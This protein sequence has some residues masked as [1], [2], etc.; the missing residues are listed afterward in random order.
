L[1]ITGYA[2]A[3]KD[4]T[5]AGAGAAFTVGDL[6]LLEAAAL[7]S[8]A[9]KD[10][11]VLEERGWALFAS[12]EH[13]ASRLR[14]S[15]QYLENHGYRDLSGQFG[16]VTLDQKATA[17]V[18]LNMGRAGQFDFTYAMQREQGGQRTSVASATW[19]VDLFRNDVRLSTTAYAE[20][21][22]SSWGVFVALSF[23]LGRS[24]TQG[25][26]QESRRNEGESS[27][28][29]QI[30]GD[31]FSQRLTWQVEGS[32]GDIERVDA[33]AD[34]DGRYADLHLAGSRM[35][36]GIGY[37]AGVAQSFVVM[38]KQL[39]VAGRIDDAFTVVDIEDSPGVTVALENRT[40]GRTDGQG[41]LF[42]PDLRSYAPNAI[43]IDPRDLPP[44]ASIGDP[45]M[46]VA[47]RERA[48]LITRFPVSRAPSALV[49]VRMPDGAAPPVGARVLIA[50]VEEPAVVGFDGEI[51]VRGL[52]EGE[53]RMDLSWRDGACSVTFDAPAIEGTLP[54][55]GPFTCAP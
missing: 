19:G 41:R 17:S 49:T 38:D 34:W 36:G 46:R 50:G 42:I 28:T 55:L 16:Y 4:Y 1:T 27:T 29:A 35:G 6:F 13:V 3:A 25:Y 33:T 54:R 30:R 32:E 15:G 47:P 43:S 20:L 52:G 40:V 22:E 24:S 44:D 11:D 5:G 2:A 10:S 37:Q 9:P 53:N 51:Y 18:G 48:G 45:N 39:F 12:A 31:A 8:D 23:P 14:F 7:V 21:E 26:V